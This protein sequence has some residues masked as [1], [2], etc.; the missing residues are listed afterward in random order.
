VEDEVGI[1]EKNLKKEGKKGDGITDNSEH[2]KP[3][4]TKICNQSS[5]FE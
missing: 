1:I 3:E 5:I 4:N 2:G